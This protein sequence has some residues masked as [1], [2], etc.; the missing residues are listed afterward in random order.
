MKYFVACG[1]AAFAIVGFVL[2]E[3]QMRGGLQRPW[4]DGYVADGR[5]LTAPLRVL[6]VEAALLIGCAVAALAKRPDV[7]AWGRGIGV[8]LVALFFTMFPSLESNVTVGPVSDV[9]RTSQAV[10]HA[11]EVAARQTGH[12]P[13]AKEVEASVALPRPAPWLLGDAPVI[14]QVTI[15]RRDANSF[16]TA[17]KPGTIACV[18][19]D[20]LGELECRSTLPERTDA[21]WTGPRL[22]PVTAYRSLKR[23][24][25]AE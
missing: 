1:L 23:G 9:D 22:S 11:I 4:A 8:G 20:A 7:A 13:D 24:N 17:T 25:R 6:V 19:D 16:V 2:A 18:T 21:N 10:A 3:A 5:Y 14:Y 15:S 12:W